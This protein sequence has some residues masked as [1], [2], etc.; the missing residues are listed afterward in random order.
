M[1]RAQRIRYWVRPQQP[2]VGFF[3]FLFSTKYPVWRYPFQGSY[4]VHGMR[5]HFRKVSLDSEL[6]VG[7]YHLG[8]YAA[9]DGFGRSK[10]TIEVW[11]G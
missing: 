5:R 2:G 1:H 3:C 6:F 8:C 10:A 9:L 7:L 4:R 11:S